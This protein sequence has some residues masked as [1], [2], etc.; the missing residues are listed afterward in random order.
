MYVSMQKILYKVPRIVK[1]FPGGPKKSHLIIEE[2][3]PSLAAQTVRNSTAMQGTQ[4]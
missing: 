2:T 3:G 1:G 4:V